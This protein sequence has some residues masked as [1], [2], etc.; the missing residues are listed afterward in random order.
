ME[1]RYKNYTISRN[2]KPIPDFRHD[3]DFLHDEYDPPDE[4][5]GTAA[6]IKNAVKQIDEIEEDL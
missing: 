1:W 4:R 6:S 3:W 5:A 2:P